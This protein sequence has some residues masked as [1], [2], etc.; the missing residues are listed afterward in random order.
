M[1]NDYLMKAEKSPATIYKANLL[2]SISF[3]L[4]FSTPVTRNPLPVTL[5]WAFL[6]QPSGINARSIEIYKI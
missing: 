4:P 1:T 3:I 2:P 6:S 5:G